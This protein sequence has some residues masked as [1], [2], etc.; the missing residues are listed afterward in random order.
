[1]DLRIVYVPQARP[2]TAKQLAAQAQYAVTL[3]DPVVG[4]H[5]SLGQATTDE[6]GSWHCPPPD[7]KHDWVLVLAKHGDPGRR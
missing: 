1:M 7:H 6:A 5:V 2:V 3:F 4:G